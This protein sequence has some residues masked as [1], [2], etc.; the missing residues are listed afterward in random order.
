MDPTPPAATIA[1]IGDRDPAVAAHQAI[2]LALALA[3]S[4]FRAPGL[5][6]A[7]ARALLPGKRR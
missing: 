1:L 2:P 3:R 6:R 4:M 5:A 7:A